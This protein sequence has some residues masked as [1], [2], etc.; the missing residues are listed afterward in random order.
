MS[1]AGTGEALTT[2]NAS[3]SMSGSSLGQSEGRSRSHND[4]RTDGQSTARSVSSSSGSFY[5]ETF[6]ESETHG[7]SKSRSVS[8]G[9]EPVYENLPSAVHSMENMLY[10]AAQTLRS[11]KTGEA[12]V[13]YAG[14]DGIATARVLVPRV[15]TIVRSS[16]QYAALRAAILEASL[17]A[18]PAADA[19]EAIEAREAALF[20]AAQSLR[21]LANAPPADPED[22]RVPLPERNPA[23]RSH[24][25]S[26]LAA[27]QPV[28]SDNRQRRRP[29]G[30][31]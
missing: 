12:F 17:G 22:F 1:T 16:E 19:D 24:G 30:R 13:H 8:E 15:R 10:F 27:A 3:S 28:K 4:S 23:L 26:A 20:A 18:L 11:L 7:T 2:S 5:S 21:D 31:P 29:F 14:V 25:G 9:L 6:S